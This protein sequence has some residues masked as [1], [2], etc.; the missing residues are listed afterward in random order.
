MPLSC[1]LALKL[2]HLSPWASEGIQLSKITW[3]ESGPGHLYTSSS[4]A[5]ASKYRC[6]LE[7]SVNPALLSSAPTTVAPTTCLAATTLTNCMV[8]IL[9]FDDCWTC[10]DTVIPLLVKL[11]LWLLEMDLKFDTPAKRDTIRVL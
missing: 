8:L 3:G 7:L 5:L 10:D 11:F 4:E 1:A 2:P 9:V 6:L